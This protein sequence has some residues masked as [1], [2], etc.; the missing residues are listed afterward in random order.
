MVALTTVGTLQTAVGWNVQCCIDS[1]AC[2]IERMGQCDLQAIAVQEAQEKEAVRLE[3]Q[4]KIDLEEKRN[5]LPPP[6]PAGVSKSHLN[7]NPCSGTRDSIGRPSI[8]HVCRT[9]IVSEQLLIYSSP[10][11][12]IVVASYLRLSHTQR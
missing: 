10:L 3:A 12:Y 11:H 4:R 9:W 6:P 7:S 1:H 2:G 5:R 8:L